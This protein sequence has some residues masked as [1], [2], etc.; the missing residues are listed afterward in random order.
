MFTIEEK[1]MEQIATYFQHLHAKEM[2]MGKFLSGN[3]QK[4]RR[5]DD[6][7]SHHTSNKR[8]RGRDRRQGRRNFNGGGRSNSNGNGTRRGSPIS[9]RTI[10]IFP[11]HGASVLAI[12]T[13][14]TIALHV[15]EM[16]VTPVVMAT[17]AVETTN[18]LLVA[19][20]PEMQNVQVDAKIRA[21][22]ITTMLMPLVV[23]TTKVHLV[24]V[25]V[26]STALPFRRSLSMTTITSSGHLRSVS[27]LCSSTM[28]RSSSRKK[29]THIPISLM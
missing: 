20:I 27:C 23:A 18:V 29:H 14:Q 16:L 17:H 11:I 5:N 13:R 15:L 24:A 12:P 25:E 26:V 6:G 28:N 7:K 1:T 8:Q 22:S 19:K 9:A 2:K 4:R 21:M 3:A 10:L